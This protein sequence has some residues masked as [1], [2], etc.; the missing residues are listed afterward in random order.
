MFTGKSRVR[1]VYEE[2]ENVSSRLS[3]EKVLQVRAAIIWV[4]PIIIINEII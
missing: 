4:P 3:A 1:F 2:N